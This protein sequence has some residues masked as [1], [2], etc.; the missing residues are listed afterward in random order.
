MEAENHSSRGFEQ[1]LESQ[2][3]APNE[4]PTGST[5]KRGRLKHRHRY[6]RRK[7][8][9]AGGVCCEG[10]LIGDHHFRL[11]IGAQI[12]GRAGWSDAE[13][14]LITPSSITKTTVLSLSA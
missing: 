11:Q 14:K 8:F 3:L 9:R 13:R 10:E 5:S 6:W 4:Q 1:S 2:H 7:D 12:N